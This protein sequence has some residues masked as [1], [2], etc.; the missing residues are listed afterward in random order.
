MSDG[1]GGALWSLL[2]VPRLRN[3]GDA[4]WAGRG[5]RVARSST[6]IV[7][8][9]YKMRFVI[10]ICHQLLIFLYDHNVFKPMLL[11]FLLLLLKCC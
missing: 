7:W 6:E 3:E 4:G 10:L 2:A 9:V 5:E 1:G 11:L 8:P